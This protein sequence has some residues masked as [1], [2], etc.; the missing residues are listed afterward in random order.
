MGLNSRRLPFL[1]RVPASPVPRLSTVLWRRYDFPAAY[2]R[3]LIWFASAVH[4]LPP[5]FVS[6]LGAPGSSEVSSR[7]G[8]LVSRCPNFPAHHYVDATGI[9]QVSRRSIPCLCCV[10]GPRSNRHVLVSSGHV[11]AA[12]AIRTTRASA[13]AISRLSPAALAPALLRF[14]LPLLSRARLASGWLTG[15]YREG[16]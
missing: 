15:L 7:P 3:P 16:V 6:R 10:P 11:D 8:L 12:P 2:Q 5:R 9:S 13:L 1:S 4:G 14:A